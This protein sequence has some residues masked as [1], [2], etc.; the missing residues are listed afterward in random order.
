MKRTKPMYGR[1][2]G[3]N[4]QDISRESK[5]SIKYDKSCEA[6]KRIRYNKTKSNKVAIKS[7]PR[8]IFQIGIFITIGYWLARN[9]PVGQNMTKNIADRFSTA[10]TDAGKM[11]Q[12][13][14]PTNLSQQRQQKSDDHFNDVWRNAG[15]EDKNR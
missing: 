10:A 6:T 2:Q 7:L 14:D 11:Q 4:S 13:L 1:S 15:G 12:R 3:A 9:T 8:A 5:T